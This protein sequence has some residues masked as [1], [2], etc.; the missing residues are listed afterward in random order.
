LQVINSSP[1]DLAPVFEAILEKAMQLCRASGGSLRS[2]DGE[3]F[4]V[5][6]TRATPAFEGFPLDD[7]VR[8]T[9]ES[10]IGR[11]VTELISGVSTRA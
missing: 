5:L 9:P 7:R 6:A 11:N 10:A 4:G 8:P 2:Y 1:G 3:Y